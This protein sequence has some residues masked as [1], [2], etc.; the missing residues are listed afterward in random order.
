MPPTFAYV[1]ALVAYL[2]FACV[3]WSVA[4]VL[5]LFQRTR[6][7]AKK[8][9][10]AMAGSFPGV[11]IFQ[12]MSAPLVALTLLMLV[13]V[14]HLFHPP[15]VLIVI[16]AFFILSIPTVASLLGFYAGWRV[17]WELATGRS[18]RASLEADR[19]LGPIF[20]CLRRCLPFLER[21]S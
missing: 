12:I 8:M 16:L 3:V 18:A 10:A 4:I 5:A 13:G 1:L 7:F 20:R 11:F 15:E 19:L 2:L 14:S 17:A 6:A 21:V 9:A